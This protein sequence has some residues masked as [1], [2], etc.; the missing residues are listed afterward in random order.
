MEHKDMKFPLS[1]IA[2]QVLEKRYIH[3]DLGETSWEDVV[4]RVVNHV[5]EDKPILGFDSPKQSLR[6]LILDRYFVPN[7]PTLVNAGTA[8]S[9]L[10]A[11]YVV[12]FTDSIEGIAKTKYDF[13]KICQ[14]GG[15][16]GTTLSN[17]RPE[18]M[19]VGGST[20]SKAAGPIKFFNTICE[21]MK[22]MTQ[23]GFREMA[24][25]GTMSV[26]HPDIEKFIR[27]K[28]EEGVMHTTNLS[29]MADDAFMKTAIDG[30]EWTTYFKVSNDC[31]ADWNKDVH[32]MVRK[33]NASKLLDLIAEHAWRNGEPGIIFSDAVNYDTPYKHTGQTIDSTNPCIHPD[34]LVET[35]DG[36]IR[37]ADIKEP[38]MVYTRDVDGSLGLSRASASWVSRKDTSVMRITTRNGKQIKV[39]PD[40]L[41]LTHS[42]WKRA[43]RIRLGDRIVQ[44]CRARRGAAYSG[45]KLTTEHNRA[46]RME[47]RLIAEGVYGPLGNKDVH[48]IDGDTYNNAIDNLEVINHKE[49]S[50]YTAT[51]DN[52]Q[53]H[54]VRGADGMFVSTGISPKTI[55]PMPKQ[56]RSNMKNNFGNVVVDIE[57]NYE[58]VDVYDISVVNT[59]NFIADFMV[60]HNCGEQ[61]LPPYGTCNLGS[62]DVSKFIKRQDNAKP[63]IDYEGLADCVKLG[64]IF[65]DSVI[66][67]AE[68]PL[69]EIKEWVEANRPIGLGVMGFADLLLELEIPYGS[70]ES[71]RLS[72]ELVSWI[73]DSALEASVKLGKIRG[74]P[75]N[76]K[77]L[78][79]PRRNVTLLSIAP[80][81]SIALIAGCSHGIE[82]IF[83]PTT[84][85]VDK[86]GTYTI[87]HARAGANYFRSAV[88]DDGE[89]A[90]SWREHINIQAAWQRWVDSGVSKTINLPHDATIKDVR[91]G[92]VMAWKNGCKG[93]TVYRDNSRDKQ[94]LNQE[95]FYQDDAPVKRKRDRVM[96]SLTV[97]IDVGGENQYVTVSHADDKPMEVF[98][99]APSILLPDVQMRDGF[100][101][102]SSL[103]LRYGVPVEELIKELRQIPAQSLKSVPVTIA[104]VLEELY[105]EENCP[106]CG[107][108]DYVNGGGC[109][110]CN[111]CGYEKCGG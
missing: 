10:S 33:F 14:K 93:I 24:M 106:E 2:Q 15:G 44:L 110:Y 4:E 65:L 50:K 109:K 13:M 58:T 71:I 66:D 11:C 37:I 63:M 34:S 31:D 45:V 26:Y 101:R 72:E 21:D 77:L 82:P 60:V 94:V 78:P 70:E 73:Y 41:V 95:K 52:P 98:V 111:S 19:R 89:K 18:G 107:S 102:L 3:K 48:H 62:L 6:Q 30:G 46:Y 80:T 88:N 38:T 96:K 59:N 85:R 105:L 47:H 87:P 27:A 42:G 57:P 61:P 91:D 55:V 90:V 40:H 86:T 84:V 56:L 100:S 103:A 23:A 5:L 39:T 74:M 7:S 20:H 22:A 92:I 69:P 28:E 81:G 76:N 9:G 53:A 99:N 43:G 68:W 64:V 8:I 108:S 35:I 12:P 1:E 49:H 97:K 83:A 36:R 67:V 104:N 17:I 25:M 51:F 79:E 29:V 75:E 16:C 54:Q 32:S